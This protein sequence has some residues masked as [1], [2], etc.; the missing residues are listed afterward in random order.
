MNILD[1]H[2]KELCKKYRQYDAWHKRADNQIITWMLFISISFTITS[3]LLLSTN[4]LLDQVAAVS[5]EQVSVSSGFLKNMNNSELSQKGL[6]EFE[7]QNGSRSS[8]R[9]KVVRPDVSTISPTSVS[10]EI[11]LD[12][13]DGKSLTLR[14][15]NIERRGSN[16]YTWVGSVKGSSKSHAVLTVVDGYLAGTVNYVDEA[17]GTKGVYSIDWVEGDTYNLRELD[18][19]AIPD[20]PSVPQRDTLS[21][22]QISTSTAIQGDTNTIID[23]MV[24]YSNQT[25]VAAG[26]AIGAQI[27]AAID[28]ANLAY[29]NSGAGITLR[30]VHSEQLPYD[31]YGTDP[32]SSALSD[33][34]S[35]TNG[36]QSVPA[37]R[38]TYRADIVSMLIE[39]RTWCGLGYMGPADSSSFN[40]VSRDCATGNLSLAHEIGHNL[41][42]LHDPVNDPGS[43]PYAYGHGYVDS[44][45]QFRTIMAYPACGAPRV[46]YHS[47]PNLMYPNTSAPMGTVSVSDAV[48]VLKQTAPI[49]AGFRTETSVNN[50]VRSNPLI[51]ISP[52]TQSGSAGQSLSYKVSVTNK[53]NSSCSGSTFT[54]SPTLPS[55]FTQNPNNLTFNL[56]PAE[57]SIQSIVVTSSSSLPPVSYPLNFLVTNT[58][59]T[60]FQNTGTASY[61]VIIPD[62]IAPSVSISS[63]L[64]G[65]TLPTGRNATK[66]SINATASDQSGIKSIDIFVGSSLVKTC[67]GT[68]SCSYSWSYSKLKS[69]TYTIKAVATDKSLNLN[70]SSQ[71]ISVIKN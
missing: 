29:A 26:A 35:G 24:L 15:K 61:S 18:Y 68:T 10:S 48:R 11:S 38:N 19:S 27:Q 14:K 31:E 37:L 63:P 64:N 33:I 1:R 21:G 4:N 59:D 8:L 43:S 67:N 34:S 42:L 22:L 45:C 52:T 66:I 30:L 62:T 51:S 58:M 6:K 13:F 2:H 3:A 28:I 60:S 25:A 69:G 57:T 16:N 55:G 53:D 47:N 39:N 7:R 70:K 5:Q 50:C 23:I 46:A 49:V 40:V 54:V 32:F 41:G 17:K 44:A 20:E 36:A 12:L 9:S 71:T 56:Q 65:S